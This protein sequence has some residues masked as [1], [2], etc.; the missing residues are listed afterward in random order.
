MHSNNTNNTTNIVG[1]CFK[2]KHFDDLLRFKPAIGW[3]ELHPENYMGGGGTPLAQLDA[4]RQHY[5]L[6]FHSIGLSLG[7]ANWQQ[8]A[9][10]QRLCALKE[11]YQPFMFSDHLSWSYSEA[12]FFNDLLPIPYTNESLQLVCDNIDYVQQQLNTTL[13]LENPST[14]F[15]SQTSSMSETE[16][17]TNIHKRTGAGILLDVNNIYVSTI[18]N[19]LDAQAYIREIPA[20]AVK[21]IHLAGHAEEKIDEQRLLIDDHSCRVCDNVWGLYRQAIRHCGAVHTLI[22]W[23]TNIPPLQTLLDEAATA[24]SIL[25]A[26]K[27]AAA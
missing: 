7:S 13:L 15:S 20:T 12:K 25:Q 18:N 24:N 26:I 3:L 16:F 9:H 27:S 6:S 4:I 1:I 2:P 10:L 14:Y 17:L 8:H 19:G 5:P 22:E 21:E 11:R 23:D